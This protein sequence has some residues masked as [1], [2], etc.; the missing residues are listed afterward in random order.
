MADRTNP[1]QRNLGAVRRELFVGRGDLLEELRGAASRPRGG[2]SQVWAVVGDRGQ[3]KTSIVHYLCGNRNLGDEP[4]GHT[5]TVVALEWTGELARSTRPLARVLYS[6]LPHMPR[7]ERTVDLGRR[8]YESIAG[9]ALWILPLPRIDFKPHDGKQFAARVR[10]RL[11]GFGD[12]FVVLLDEIGI[13]EEAATRSLNFALE[14]ANAG[15]GPREPNVLVVLFIVRQQATEL[16]LRP[17]APRTVRRHELS[18]LD[19]ADI[20]DL[21][22]LG[23]S[24]QGKTVEN[25]LADAILGLTGGRPDVTM[26]LLLDAWEQLGDSVQLTRQHLV[27]AAR[28]G[29]EV[30]TRTQGSLKEVLAVAE[31][32]DKVR[33]VLLALSSLDASQCVSLRL[34]SDWLSAVRALVGSDRQ[35]DEAF[36]RAWS[37]LV[38]YQVVIGDSSGHSRFRG[39]LLRTELAGF[40]R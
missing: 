22:H 39:E 40:C 36:E 33:R 6:Q 21:L 14:V 11:S 8:A 7:L 17:N 20:Q 3:G 30:L 31:G 10:S 32:D 15:G 25:G 2:L 12:T 27:S 23:L 18:D 28:P 24:G 5:R 16:L 35:T 4:S 26:A 38:R 19:S 29:S 34:P 37:E 9:G 13:S 1:F